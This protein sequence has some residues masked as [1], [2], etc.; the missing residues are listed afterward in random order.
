MEIRPKYRH[1]LLHKL[2]IFSLNHS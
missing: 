2:G 1:N